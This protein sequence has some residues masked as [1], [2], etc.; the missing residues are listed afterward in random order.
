MRAA[1]VVTAAAARTITG[2]EC[3][4]E[5]KKTKAA[6]KTATISVLAKGK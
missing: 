4:N 6:G 5:A 2:K 1:A 3:C